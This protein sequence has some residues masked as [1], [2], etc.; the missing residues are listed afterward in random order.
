LD[1]TYEEE[2]IMMFTDDMQT[3]TELVKVEAVG[4][5]LLP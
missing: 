4:A 3:H 2:L 5:K 1:V